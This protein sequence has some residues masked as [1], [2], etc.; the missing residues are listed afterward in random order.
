VG[1]LAGAEKWRGG[2]EKLEAAASLAKSS[3][4]FAIMVRSPPQMFA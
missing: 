3:E 2:N 1:G 4:M